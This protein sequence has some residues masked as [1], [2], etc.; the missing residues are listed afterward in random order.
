MTSQKFKFVKLWNWLDIQKE[1]DEK[2]AIAK[3]KPVSANLWAD[4]SNV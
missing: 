2:C 3:R 4:I 1:E